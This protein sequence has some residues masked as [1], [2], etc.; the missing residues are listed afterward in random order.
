MM[1]ETLKHVPQTHKYGCSFCN[2]YW[3]SVGNKI[4]SIGSRAK[5]FTLVLSLLGEIVQTILLN[6]DAVVIIGYQC[7]D[8]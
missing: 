3:L 1:S 8:G 7:F 5:L 6:F 4:T 2:N